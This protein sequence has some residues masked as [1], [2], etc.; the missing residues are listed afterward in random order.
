MYL[1][2]IAPCFS[3]CFHIVSKLVLKPCDI[4]RE[5]KGTCP[6]AKWKRDNRS[7]LRRTI[8]Y[9]DLEGEFSSAES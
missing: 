5:S 1:L 7:D 6:K 3:I 2:I 4:E 8:T 9:K